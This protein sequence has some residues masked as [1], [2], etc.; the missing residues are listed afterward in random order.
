MVEYSVEAGYP[1]GGDDS[2]KYFM[3]QIHFDNSKLSSSKNLLR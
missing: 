2:V 1:I 3:L